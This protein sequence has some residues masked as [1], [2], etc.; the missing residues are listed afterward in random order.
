MTFSGFVV[1]YHLDG[2]RKGMGAGPEAIVSS[3]ALSGVP[4]TGVRTIVVDEAANEVQSCIAID[5]A[6]AANARAARNAGEALLVMSGNCHACLGTLAGT[7]SDVAVIWFDAHGDLNTPDTTET[8]FFDGMALACAVGWTWRALTKKIPGFQPV[9]EHHVLLVGA[10]DLDAGER[11]RLL[12]SRIRHFPTPPLQCTAATTSAFAA[13]LTTAPQP[14]AAYV[15]IDL[16]ILDPS[17]MRANGY[18]VDGGVSVSWLEAALRVIADQKLVVGIGLTSYDP[19]CHDA[20][21]VAKIVR[22]LLN[23]TFPR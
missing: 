7:G 17:E 11:E 18:A 14:K 6:L 2:L 20:A 5:S 15:H 12:R 4:L 8:G 3:G 10:R 1:P 22:R 9:P 21:T 16:D 19:T 23:A 13:A